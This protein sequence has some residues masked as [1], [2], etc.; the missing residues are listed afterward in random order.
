M[1][2]AAGLALGAGKRAFSC[3]G[4]EEDR[5]SL[6]TAES[7]AS[8]ASGWRRPPIVVVGIGQPSQFVADGAADD[9]GLQGGRDGVNGRRGK[10]KAVELPFG[11][12]S[13]M[14]VGRWIPVR[15]AAS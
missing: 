11:V 7:L 6:P 9:E 5:K 13:A 15:S 2:A 1:V 8:M 3:A 4:V 14:W 10:A 12:F